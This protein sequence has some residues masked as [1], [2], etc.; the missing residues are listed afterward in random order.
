VTALA[1]RIARAAA[2]LTLSSCPFCGGAA[3]LDCVP[4][5]QP[6]GREIW[7]IN[8]PACKVGTYGDHDAP[9][10]AAMWNRRA[11]DSHGR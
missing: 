2:N 8:C 11:E 7:C 10:V 5:L 3:R 4:G 9:S 6:E 1:D